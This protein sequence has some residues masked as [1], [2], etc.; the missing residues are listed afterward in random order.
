MGYMGG[1][2]ENYNLIYYV[3]GMVSG[4][5]LTLAFLL[6]NK[7]SKK[8]KVPEKHKT[9]SKIE[10]MNFEFDFDYNF[11]NPLNG[12][13]IAFI[14]GETIKL[15]AQNNKDGLDQISVDKGSYSIK[16]SANAN[17]IKRD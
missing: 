10:T 4:V 1:I 16:M 9:W 3:L 7:D 2:M 11:N 12:N 6:T 14:I 17:F 13:E 5:F 15:R 8:L